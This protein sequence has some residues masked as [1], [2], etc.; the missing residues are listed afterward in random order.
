M[1]RRDAVRAFTIWAARA[2]GLQNERGSIEK[3]KYADFVIL[4]EDLFT[5]ARERFLSTRVRETWVAGEK[6]FTAED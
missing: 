1:S 6:V 2:A 3:G 4:S 5:V